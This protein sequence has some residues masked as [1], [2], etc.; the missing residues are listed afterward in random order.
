[1]YFFVSS[2]AFRS[3]LAISIHST[4]LREKGK[5]F[6]SLPL[7]LALVTILWVQWSELFVRSWLQRVKIHLLSTYVSL[8]L[9]VVCSITLGFFELK[10]V[11]CCLVSPL[12]CDCK[13]CPKKFVLPIS[14]SGGHNLVFVVS[15]ERWELKDTLRTFMISSTIGTQAQLYVVVEPCDK[16]LCLHVLLTCNRITCCVATIFL[17]CRLWNK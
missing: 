8:Q 16:S 14:S 5:H 9:F 4:T 12:I 6:L 1:M 2:L 13:G 15:W 7:T 11:R 10:T 3:L 17:V